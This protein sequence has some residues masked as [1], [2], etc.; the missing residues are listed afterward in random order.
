[1]LYEFLLSTGDVVDTYVVIAHYTV[2]NASTY[3]PDNNKIFDHLHFI[4]KD[5]FMI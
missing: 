4:L 5:C 2:R 3:N 1:M